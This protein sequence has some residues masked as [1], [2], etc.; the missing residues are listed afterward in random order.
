MSPGD[1]NRR[2]P[3]GISGPRALPGQHRPDAQP[4]AQCPLQHRRPRP[5][6]RLRQRL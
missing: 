6:P 4:Y 1:S 2:K 3:A 5:L